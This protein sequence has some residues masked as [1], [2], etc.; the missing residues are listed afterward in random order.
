ME[1]GEFRKLQEVLLFENFKFEK[2]AD[3]HEKESEALHLE[4]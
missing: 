4:M 3:H 2:N 1:Q